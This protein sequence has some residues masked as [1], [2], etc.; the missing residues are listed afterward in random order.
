[1]DLDGKLSQGVPIGNDISFLLAEVVLAQVD[2]AM[3]SAATR[4][5]RWFDDYEFGVDTED[6][7]AAM[8]KRLNRQL[9]KFKLRLNPRK[10]VIKKLPLPAQ[11]EWQDTLRQA[12][13]A[14]F[15]SA[16]EMVKYFDLAFRLREQFPDAPVL[17]YAMG[18][19]FKLMCPATDVAR[20]AQSCITQTLLCEPGAAQ[21]AFAL[22]IFWRLNGLTL[23]LPLITNT[24]SQVII[25]HEACGFSS[26]VA[27]AL[28]FCLDQRIVLNG[29]A[30]RILS[31]FDDDCTAL[32]ALHMDCIGLLPKG[33]HKKHISKVLKNADL[34][35]EHWLLAYESVRQGF[36]GVCRRIVQRNPFFNALLARDVTFY[37]TALPPY[38]TVIHVGGAPEWV[39]RQWLGLATGVEPSEKVRGEPKVLGFIRED[40]ARLSPQPTS[41][42][43][44]TAQLIGI[45]APQ[46]DVG[47]EEQMDVYPA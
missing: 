14:R 24:I 26:D 31:V 18:M 21:K 15:A 16:R 32:Q 20:V 5:F 19:L 23:D 12:G 6:Q 36:L 27:W 39:V 9:A 7:A 46:A 17:T 8:L 37:R 30:G 35:R 11:D 43:D 45:L 33:F 38:A 44:L 13:A 1:M 28:A 4:S 10:T 29:R 22:L 3:G 42:D 25:R 40:V 41:V 2:R 34:D 47:E